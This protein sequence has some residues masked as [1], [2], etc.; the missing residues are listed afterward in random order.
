M[1]RT[2]LAEPLESYLGSCNNSYELSITT[3]L[4]VLGYT[5][6]I[7]NNVFNGNPLVFWGF[8]ASTGGASNFHQFCIDVPDLI[9]DSSVVNIESEKCNHFEYMEV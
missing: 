4:L 6:D 7:V 1:S 2:A 3:I 9:I 8:T 5:G